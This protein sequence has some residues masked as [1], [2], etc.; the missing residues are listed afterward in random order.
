MSM[1]VCN[2]L[3]AVKVFHDICHSCT[4]TKIIYSS[5]P[6]TYQAIT[7]F[8]NFCEFTGIECIFYHILS[9]KIFETIFV[10]MCIHNRVFFCFMWKF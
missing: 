9:E 10:A 5:W 6:Q 4:R 8:A 7:N 2:V 1:C 3:C